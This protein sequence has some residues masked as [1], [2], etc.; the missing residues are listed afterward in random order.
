M[1]QPEIFRLPTS[2]S[3]PRSTIWWGMLLLIATEATLFANI[4]TA[5]FTS[6]FRSPVWP[7]EGIPMPDLLVPGIG[8]LILLAS[9]LP[10]QW[11]SSGIAHGHQGRLKLGLGLSFLLG[12]LFVGIQGYTALQWPFTIQTN[13]YASAFITLTAFHGAHVVV[14]LVMNAVAQL[15]AW[16]GYFS[17]Q[18][19]M[20]VQATAMYWHFVNAILIVVFATLHLSPR[21]PM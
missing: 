5:Y 14:G 13:A 3:G 2:T 10:M 20:G 4:I 12:V 11:A 17:A 18:R 9:S 8:A 6:R 7:P 16:L 21:I 19:H 15:L 1:S